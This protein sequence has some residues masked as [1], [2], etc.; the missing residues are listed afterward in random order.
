MRHFTDRAAADLQ[1]LQ[2]IK[3]SAV[4]QHHHLGPSLLGFF[5][6]SVEKR[7]TKLSKISECW[8]TLVPQTLL[9]HCALES[10]HAGTL[11]V[12]VDTSSHLYELKQLLLAGLEQ[13]ILLACKSAGLRKISL[14][15]G[16]WYDGDS[17][18]ERKI[19]FE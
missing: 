3:Q 17:P 1:R 6:Q 4:P 13:Q 16:R 19:R 5:R 10:F 18:R 2:H 14:K 11:K 12:I 15:R 7:Q 8:A 9:E